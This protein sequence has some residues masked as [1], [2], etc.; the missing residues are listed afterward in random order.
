MPRTTGPAKWTRGVISGPKNGNLRLLPAA[1]SVSS[2]A[3][4]SKM[5]PIKSQAIT[6]RF[7]GQ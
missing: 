7:A 2:S 4:R 1:G 3:A 6:Q 5:D